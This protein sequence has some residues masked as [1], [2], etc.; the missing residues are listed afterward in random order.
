M[1]LFT[2][3]K[4]EAVDT[5]LYGTLSEEQKDMYEN[6][7]FLLSASLTNVTKFLT[8]KFDLSTSTSVLFVH[9]T[10]AVSPYW[11]VGP[12]LHPLMAHVPFRL[13]ASTPI[14]TSQ[15]SCQLDEKASCS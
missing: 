9:S 5:V 14:V 11:P 1:G 4:N 15:C 13:S 6:M 10:L 12:E 7:S 3:K 2:P 8:M